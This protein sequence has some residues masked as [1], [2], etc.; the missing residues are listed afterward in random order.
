MDVF[1]A[2]Q[3][4]LDRNRQVHGYEL[5]FRASPESMAFDPAAASR[6][7]GE[8]IANSVFAS[9]LENLRSGKN[10]F[11]NF[12]R[13][14]LL[15]HWYKALPPENTF[16]EV[17][18]SVSPDAEVLAAC[19]VAVEQGYRIALDD[20]IARPEYEPL[21]A[22]ANLIKVEVQSIPRPEQAELVRSCH[23]RGLKVLAEKVE[24]YE[25]FEWACGAGYDFFQGYFFAQPMV[26]RGRQIETVK[27]SYLRLLQE[28]QQA[29]LDFGR[30]TTLISED[31]AL[32][33]K[34]T[35]YASSTLFS[36]RGQ[37]RSVQQ[38][39]ATLGEPNIRR[40]AA[41]V[42]LTSSAVNKPGELV[43]CS[44]V[45]A[46]FC[47]L[48]STV[49]RPQVQHQAFLTGLFSLLD[50]LLDR[51]LDE[52]LKELDLASPITSALLKTA[53]EHDL[54]AGI[55]RLACRYEEAAWQAVD[56]LLEKFQIPSALARWSYGEA[57][58]WAREALA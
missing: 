41:L 7:T 31:V 47:E 35:R 36:R 11:V 6:A 3:A 20:Y 57:L 39:L 33:Y 9:G 1:V 53:P 12:D 15:G 23:A 43:T 45:R 28:T 10:A 56:A 32:T 40:W 50:A 58:K 26:L 16:L 2:R 54:N 46:R 30:L 17:L 5:L 25:Q 52:V 19:Q 49:V 24:D 4:I 13:G 14:M 8:V 22:I 55:Y 29:E 27:M 21:L 42:L 38:A 44:L 34:L 37:I 51:P 48:M 18:E